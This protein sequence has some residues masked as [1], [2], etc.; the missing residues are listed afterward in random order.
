MQSGVIVSCT[1]ASGPSNPSTDPTR[2]VWSVMYLYQLDAGGWQQGQVIVG[3]GSPVSGFNPAS[4]V[5]LWASPTSI[6]TVSPNP[7]GTTNPIS[8]PCP[9]LV[10]AAAFGLPLK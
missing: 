1:N 8:L 4:I 6:I 10:Q 2:S 5:P 9:P 3:Y 7:P